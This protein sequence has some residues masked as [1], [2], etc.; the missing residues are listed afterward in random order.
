MTKTI[1]I[2][3]CILSILYWSCNSSSAT[4]EEH[5]VFNFVDKHIAVKRT[6]SKTGE[7]EYKI[8]LEVKSPLQLEGYFVL[9]DTF[10][11]PVQFIDSAKWK[12]APY[13]I[14]DKEIR[15]VFSDPDKTVGLSMPI[16]N[17]N[18]FIVDYK[19][20]MKGTNK[21][22]INGTAFYCVKDHQYLTPTLALVT[23]VDY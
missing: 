23:S 9:D 18:S 11:N 6:I 5:K 17:C 7:D 8:V 14:S 15:F 12:Y 13:Y 16:P 22:K 10:A 3:F 2:F 1:N 19:I 4:K 20:K 21:I